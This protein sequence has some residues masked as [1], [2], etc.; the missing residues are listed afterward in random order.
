MIRF[1][2]PHCGRQLSVADGKAGKQGKCPACQTVLRVPP[3]GKKPPRAARRESLP[4]L[5]SS[6]TLSDTPE[7]MIDMT[8]MVDIVFFLLIF[9]MVTS[10]MAKQASIAMPSMPQSSSAESS[11]ASA[12][13]RTLEDYEEDQDYIIVRI[14]PDN[15]I[16]VDEQMVHSAP[17]V[18]AS[19]RQAVSRVES[20]DEDG[21]SVLVVGHPD[22]HHGTAVMVLDAVHELGIANVRLSVAAED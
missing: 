6:S 13:P 1:A 7:E 3:S 4:P 2:C 16:Y 11:S 18:T 14:E 12:A 8:A 5:V 19:L 20:R 15:S 22:A 9:F 17:D 21:P 10:L